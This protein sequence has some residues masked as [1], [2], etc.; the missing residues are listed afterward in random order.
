MQVL[1]TLELLE[2]LVDAWMEDHALELVKEALKP[3]AR[4]RPSFK[5]QLSEWTKSKKAKK[6]SK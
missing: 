4:K 3:A 1:L 6:P 2:D 5:E